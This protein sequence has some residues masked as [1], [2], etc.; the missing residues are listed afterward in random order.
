MN[1]RAFLGV[2]AGATVAGR[3]NPKA[4]QLEPTH[5]QVVRLELDENKLAEKLIV[6][7][8]RG[9]AVYTALRTAAKRPV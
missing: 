8:K 9:D 4:T 7:L 6:A 5:V 1:R 2:L 3:S